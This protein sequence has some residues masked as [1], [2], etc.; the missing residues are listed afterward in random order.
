MGCSAP[1]HHRS[2]APPALFRRTE[3][4]S[5]ARLFSA[6]F[7]SRGCGLLTTACADNIQHKHTCAVGF[8][9]TSH[10]PLTHISK[11]FWSI[12][13]VPPKPK[14][15]MVALTKIPQGYAQLRDWLTVAAPVFD[16]YVL[17]KTCFPLTIKMCRVGSACKV[18]AQVRPCVWLACAYG[19]CV[20][21][22]FFCFGRGEITSRLSKKRVYY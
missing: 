17:N 8:L 10:P 15:D 5:A 13:H 16:K 14:E 19:G 1:P 20:A 2:T 7:T 22:Y 9:M 21:W 6:L 12:D 11:G 3:C 18:H 4:D